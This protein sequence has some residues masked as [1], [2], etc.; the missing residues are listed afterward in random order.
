MSRLTL[1]L[2][3]ARSGKSGRAQ[4]LAEATGLAVTYVATAPEIAG[5]AEWRARIEHHRQHRPA[6]WRLHEEPLALDA[7]LQA[8]AV[9]EGCTIVDCLTLWLANQLHAGHAAEESA[10]RLS[11]LLPQLPGDIIL[12]SNETGMGIVPESPLA[13]SFRDAQGRL[14]Q[15]IAAVADRV[16]LVVAGIPV[17]VKG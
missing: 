8:V 13:R 17:T 15:A 4:Q 16:E 11:A 14:N 5:D 2:G 12:V 10:T 3:G 9:A 6:H 7:A 1:V